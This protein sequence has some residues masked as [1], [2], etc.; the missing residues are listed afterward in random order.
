MSQGATKKAIAYLRTR[1]R[2]P[3]AVASAFF[4]L[5]IS[6]M[7]TKFWW[8]VCTAVVLRGSVARPGAAWALGIYPADPRSAGDCGCGRSGEVQG[9]HSAL[10]MTRPVGALGTIRRR[11][12][13]SSR[14]ACG[15]RSQAPPRP[16]LTSSERAQR[17]LFTLGP[18]E[19]PTARVRHHKSRQGALAGRQAARAFL[20][21]IYGSMSPRR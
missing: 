21:L 9:H 8:C 18:L 2:G 12:P 1:L 13:I 6:Q 19:T 20:W 15:S 5:K 14:L 4:H 16:S 17:T 10:R 7:T 3:A 11:G